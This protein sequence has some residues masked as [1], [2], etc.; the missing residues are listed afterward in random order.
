MGE[1]AN[2]ARWAAI[3][4]PFVRAGLCQTCESANIAYSFV[5][6]GASSRTDENVMTQG[7]HRAYE[8][9]YRL[10]VI[11]DEEVIRDL[12]SIQLGR[13]GFAMSVAGS[14]QHALER[15]TAERLDLV[16][17]DLKLADMSGAGP[18]Q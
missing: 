6:V 9:V 5:W 2:G 8:R 7:G 4:G 16:L 13:E 1:E 14:A 15:L 10:L 18:P 11:D 17:L 12:F 3:S